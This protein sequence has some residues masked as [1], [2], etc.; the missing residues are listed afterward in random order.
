V[1]F[2]LRSKPQF[3]PTLAAWH[4]EE[5]S[6]LYPGETLE[7]R[8]KRMEEHLGTAPIPSMYIWADGQNVIGSAAIVKHDMETKP[9]L[10]PWLANVY[11]HADYRRSGVGTALVNHVVQKACELGYDQLFLYTPHKEDFYLKLGW[12]TVAKEEFYGEDV[13]IMKIETE[14]VTVKSES[15][16]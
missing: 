4:Y 15:L 2:D 8:I 12:H 9:E 6:H 14:Q 13:T 1:I 11:V 3:I 16:Y 7:G 10:T 5:W